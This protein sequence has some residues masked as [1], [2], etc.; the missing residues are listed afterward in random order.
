MFACI[1]I[2]RDDRERH[3][4]MF[5]GATFNKHLHCRVNSKCIPLSSQSVRLV[6]V[7]VVIN[8]ANFVSCDKKVKSPSERFLP[9]GR[10]KSSTGRCLRV[11][12]S[13]RRASYWHSATA[14]IPRPSAIFGTYT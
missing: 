11:Q 1:Y 13:D 14:S 6:R 2:V 4:E 7:S 12:S 10:Q 5:V 3:R 8:L 9:R